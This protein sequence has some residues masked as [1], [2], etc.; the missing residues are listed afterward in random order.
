[1]QDSSYRDF[2]AFFIMFL[3]P[4]VFKLWE[5]A[6]N[7]DEEKDHCCLALLAWCSYAVSEHTRRDIT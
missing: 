3:Y 2:V 1:M 6:G 5:N 4:L 7:D